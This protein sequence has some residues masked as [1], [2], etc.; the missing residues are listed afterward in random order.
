MGEIYQRYF[1][2]WAEAGGGLH[3]H[4]DSMAQWSKWGSWGLLRHSLEDPRKSPK[5]MSAMG[6]AKKQGQ[7]VRIPG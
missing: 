1:E 4:F 6:W 5:F 7:N 2:G 3:C